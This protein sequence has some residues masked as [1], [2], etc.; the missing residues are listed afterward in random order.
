VRSLF[1][2]LDELIGKARASKRSALVKILATGSAWER[3]RSE[4]S[5]FPSVSA[6]VESSSGVDPKLL[7]IFSGVQFFRD[8]SIAPALFRFVYAD[9]S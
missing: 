8:D 1:L 3:L 9:R 2:H 7:G 4:P 5:P 6:V